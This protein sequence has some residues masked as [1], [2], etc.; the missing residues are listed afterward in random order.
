MDNLAKPIKS[1]TYKFYIKEK[2][3][4]KSIS[5]PEAVYDELK[6][7]AN[8]DQ[9]S[10]W[11][12]YVNTKMKMIGK[13]LISLGGLDYACVDMKILFRR[14]LQNSSAAFFIVHNHPNGDP[15]PSQGDKV[16]TEQVQKAAKLLE[17]KFLDHVIVAG[18]EYYSFNSN[19][20]L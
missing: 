11:A 14:I 6:D 19:G 2:V 15:E 16:L 8:A 20:D 7:L 5:S 9:E 13:D 3:S 1:S 4:E 10:L 17:L 12:I 18:N